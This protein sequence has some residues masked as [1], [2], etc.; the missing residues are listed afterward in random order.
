MDSWPARWNGSVFM[1]FSKAWDPDLPEEGPKEQAQVPKPIAGVLF[2]ILLGQS[3]M[4]DPG[5]E[6]QLQL[7]EG[8]AGASNSFH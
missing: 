1:I 3:P 4:W 2:F 7:V 8:S 5:S 6:E